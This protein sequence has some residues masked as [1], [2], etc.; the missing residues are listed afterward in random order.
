MSEGT[1]LTE[2]KGST[3]APVVQTPT[4]E[5]NGPQVVASYEPALA[6]PEND[7][8]RQP[9]IDELLA[10]I[11]RLEEQYAA[12]QDTKQ[13]EER[14]AQRVSTRLRRKAVTNMRLPEPLPA[15]T[16]AP[17]PSE[18]SP[19]G[20]PSAT[21]PAAMLP[22]PDAPAPMARALPADVATAIAPVATVIAL[23]APLPDPPVAVIAPTVTEPT[24][25]V[26]RVSWLWRSWLFL[27]ILHEFRVT[28][29]MLVDPRYR[30]TW[31]GRIV[32]IVV[33]VLIVLS[34]F[35]KL[36]FLFPWNLAP[37]VGYYCNKIFQIALSFIMFKVL[38]REVVRYREKV[39]DA[40]RPLRL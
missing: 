12:L 2:D 20:E 35:E 3:G 23:P 18:V 15:A 13:L 29:R 4:V 34:D 17:P 27:D 22:L 36:A 39:P 11:R 25:P 40:P 6:L 14:V 5:S 7:R 24:G 28:L 37:G 8:H 9:T 38:E 10:R 19:L 31:P 26:S 1:P 33:L 32:P 16:D 21:A 30:L